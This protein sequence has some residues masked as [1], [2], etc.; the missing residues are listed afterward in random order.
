MLIDE[1]VHIT[2]CQLNI[3]STSGK[4]EK[5]HNYW[6]RVRQNTVTRPRHSQHPRIVSLV[7]SAHLI[8]A[9]L[10]MTAAVC[11]TKHFAPFNS[12]PRIASWLVCIICIIVEKT[13]IEWKPGIPLVSI[14]SCVVQRKKNENT[15]G[16]LVVTN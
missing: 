7:L 9:V 1:S 12:Y 14:N 11:D 15:S 16:I 2:V 6:D 3:S 10:I 8:E 13:K 4:E 5:R